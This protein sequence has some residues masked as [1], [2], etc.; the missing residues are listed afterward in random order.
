MNRSA[1]DLLATAMLFGAAL[2]F[3][4]C[5]RFE[6]P[7]A[8]LTIPIEYPIENY[9]VTDRPEDFDAW[10]FEVRALRAELRNTYP[11]DEARPTREG[12]SREQEFLDKAVDP[13]SIL[14]KDPASFWREPVHL[15][16]W[17]IVDATG[18]IEKVL[19]VAS[20]QSPETDAKIISWCLEGKSWKPAIV[21]GAPTASVRSASISLGESKWHIGYWHKVISEDLALALAVVA[22]ALAVRGLWAVAARRLRKRP[23]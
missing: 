13:A 14:W 3:S 19:V 16:W 22:I 10:K 9:R 4:G 15:S 5:G 17:E 21:D 8:S 18:K 11:M 23:S 6:P 20:N 2:L 12:G 1:P 7:P